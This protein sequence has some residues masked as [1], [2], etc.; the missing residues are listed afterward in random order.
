MPLLL[1]PSQT[2]SS[3]TT[4][5]EVVSS[6]IWAASQ[7]TVGRLIQLA[8]FVVL[9]RLIGP[10]EIGIIGIVLLSINSLRHF[11]NIGIHEA[12]VQ[13]QADD[14]DDYLDT[15]WVL[16]IGRGVVITMAVFVLAPF[17]AS[18]FGAPGVTDL[19]R[20][21][22]FSPT[23]ISL[24]NPGT[25]YFQKDLD[26]QKLFVYR[27]SGD[28]VQ[29]LVAVGYALVDPTAWSF[30]VGFLAGN[31]V[32]SVV[33]YRIVGYRPWPAFDRERAADLVGYGKWL[34]GSSILHFLY[35]EGDDAFVG[36]FLTPVALG[37]YQYSYKLSNAPATEVAEIVSSVIFPTVSKLQDDA[38]LVRDTFLKTVQLTSLVMFPMALGIVVVAPSF[39][40]AV[41]GEQWVPMVPAMQVLA[42]FGLLRGLTKTIHP[43][44]KALGRPD[45]ITKVSALR[46]GLLAVAIYPA[47]A[48]YGFTGTALVVT[49]IYLFPVVPLEIYM[50][51]QTTGVT[52][53]QLGYELLYPLCASLGMCA[54]T[55]YV[56]RV[57]SLSPVAMTLLLPV[58][59]VVVYSVSILALD[60]QFDW[61]LQDNIR[62]VMA[63]FRQ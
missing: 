11:T 45:Y 8:M 31:A 50:I 30:V 4:T 28:A 51:T 2:D 54:S 56:S 21:A 16:G 18:V 53:T 10:R 5:R 63:D 46:V 36:W 34:T 55:W 15:A 57:V 61:G 6:I 13:K 3:N 62:R 25:V 7:N 19:I 17:L 29:A 23:I 32:R 12:L 58:V 43:V 59:G 37:L 60:F 20:V 40:R 35:G 27:V 42:V 44:W 52:Y 14:I 26:F 24:R 33:S 41:L 1:V 22:A 47:T 48:A 49:G 38:A 9:A 39:V